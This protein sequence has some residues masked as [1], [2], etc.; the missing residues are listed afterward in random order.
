MHDGRN[1][2][3]WKSWRFL[4]VATSGTVLSIGICSTVVYKDLMHM[5]WDFSHSGWATFFSYLQPAI[6]VVA[7][8]L[9]L[10]GFITALHRSDQTAKQ[11]NR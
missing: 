11:P 5:D 6:Y 9:A 4:I 2:S 3:L 8:T 10:L 7:G 1:E